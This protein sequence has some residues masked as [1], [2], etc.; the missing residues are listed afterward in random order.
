MFWRD[1]LKRTHVAMAT[2]T[3]SHPD[4]ATSDGRTGNRRSDYASCALCGPEGTVQRR[5][6]A[7]ASSVMRSTPRASLLL[8]LF[9]N[10]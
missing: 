2:Q 1:V 9:Q 10:T 3:M 6:Y 5:S 8:C 7:A 4:H